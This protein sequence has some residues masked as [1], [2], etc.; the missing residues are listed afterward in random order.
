MLRADRVRVR[1]RGE[2]ERRGCAR[3]PRLRCGVGWLSGVLQA[4]VIRIGEGADRVVSGGRSRIA[5]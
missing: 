1:L 2:R 4:V 3:G 5:G